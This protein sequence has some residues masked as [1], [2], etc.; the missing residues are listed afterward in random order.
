MA[1]VKIDEAYDTEVRVVVPSWAVAG[2]LALF[3]WAMKRQTRV[4][5]LRVRVMK[6]AGPP[7]ASRR[8]SASASR[9]GR[10]G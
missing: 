5:H 3:E 4:D 10:R 1:V 9:A 7:K 6:V 2:V 8:S